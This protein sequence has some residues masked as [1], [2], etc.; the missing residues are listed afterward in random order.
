MEKID[1]SRK[2]ECTNCGKLF[3]AIVAERNSFDKCP[4]CYSEKVVFRDSRVPV[5]PNRIK[6]K[7]EE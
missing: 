1:V 5:I 2:L 4:F 6:V 3:S 7:E